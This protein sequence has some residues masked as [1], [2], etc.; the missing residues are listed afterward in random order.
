MASTSSLSCLH[1]KFCFRD[2]PVFIR[3]S[4]SI[5]CIFGTLLSP[6]F[7]FLSAFSSHGRQNK[8]TSF[9]SLL[10]SSF[11]FEVSDSHFLHIW[12]L[13]YSHSFTSAFSLQNTLLQSLHVQ[14]FALLL[15]NVIV[16]TYFL[17]SSLL[18][19]R[20]RTMRYLPGSRA[21]PGLMVTC[22][23]PNQRVAGSIPPQYLSL[24]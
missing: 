11:S 7:K 22:W 16:T 10:S 17:F 15:E 23:T 1:S 3:V 9:L 20:T 18:I 24:E 6:F 19:I 4:L 13:Q 12:S 21:P 14:S 2:Y 5:L 8:Y